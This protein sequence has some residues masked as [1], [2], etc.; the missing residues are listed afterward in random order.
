MTPPSSR[1][2]WRLE[3]HDALPSTSDLARARAEAG[4]PEGLAVLARRQTRAR[5]SRGR[6]WSTPAGNLAISILLRPR[7][8]ARDAAGMSLLAG[9]ALAEAVAEILPPGPTLALKWPND[10]L[11][12]GNKL[13]GILL[14]SQGDGQGGVAW[15]IPGIGVN[16]AHAPVLPD[17]IAACLADHMPAPLPEVFARRLLDRLGHWCAVQAQ[18]GFAPVFAA[19]LGHAQKPGSPMS[20][21][22]GSDLLSGS[23]A[24][25]DADGSLLLECG[26]GLRR[27]STGEVL[28]PQGD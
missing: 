16:L 2:S 28:L 18:S 13:A 22:L 17:R 26:G 15:V 9:L 6:G 14:E 12:D 5:G 1:L 24:G 23:F 20:L 10:V 27:F 11:L 25:L 3:I 21:K 4:E 7:L 8:A 19:W